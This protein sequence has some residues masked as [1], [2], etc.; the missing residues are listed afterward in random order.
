MGPVKGSFTL[1]TTQRTSQ[2]INDTRFSSIREYVLNSNTLSGSTQVDIND[3]IPGSVIYRIDLIV[4]SAFSDTSGAQHDIQI[5]CDNGGVI[6]DSKWND[7]NM[8][9]SY[10]TNCYANIRTSTDMIHVIHSLGN[11]ISGSALLRF[12]IYNNVDTYTKMLTSDGLY[13]RTVNTVG[14]DVTTE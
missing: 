3:L 14:V 8:I 7:P 12:Y 9:G 10:T 2:L 4:L 6:M 1:P 11:L 5:T 13:Y